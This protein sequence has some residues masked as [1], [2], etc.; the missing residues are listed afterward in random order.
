MSFA[1]EYFHAKRAETG[2]FVSARSVHQKS[3][4]WRTCWLA[5]EA[6]KNLTKISQVW[7]G[8]RTMPAP[9]RW[10]TSTSEAPRDSQRNLLW[11]GKGSADDVGD[12]AQRQNA[13]QRLG[14]AYAFCCLRTC[15]TGGVQT[16]KSSAGSSHGSIANP[17][18]SHA[19][20]WPCCEGYRTRG[21]PDSQGK[22]WKLVQNSRCLRIRGSQRPKR[23]NIFGYVLELHFSDLGALQPL[24]WR[25]GSTSSSH[26]TKLQMFIIASFLWEQGCVFAFWYPQKSKPVLKRFWCRTSIYAALPDTLEGHG[27]EHFRSNWCLLRH[28]RQS[29][30]GLRGLECALIG[31]G[32]HAIQ[33]ASNMLSHL[34]V[35]PAKRLSGSNVE[36]P[37]LRLRTPAVPA[38]AVPWYSRHCFLLISKIQSTGLCSWYLG[39]LLLFWRSKNANQALSHLV[40]ERAEPVQRLRPRQNARGLG[41]R[42]TLK[43]LNCAQVWS[44]LSRGQEET[45][46]VQ[47]FKPVGIAVGA[48]FSISTPILKASKQLTGTGLSQNFLPTEK[49]NTLSWNRRHKRHPCLSCI[50]IWDSNSMVIMLAS[51]HLGTAEQSSTCFAKACWNSGHFVVQNLCCLWIWSLACVICMLTYLLFP[52]PKKANLH[53]T[54]CFSVLFPGQVEAKVD[55]PAELDRK[56][57]QEAVQLCAVLEPLRL[58]TKLVE[59]EER[60]PASL[61]L[62]LFFQTSET[63][64]KRKGS[65]PLQRSFEK[66]MGCSADFQLAPSP[67]QLRD[68]LSKDIQAIRAKHLTGTTGDDLLAASTFLTFDSNNMTCGRVTYQKTLCRS[69]LLTWH[70]KLRASTRTW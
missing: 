10:S 18:R 55:G 56:E 33:L 9:A 30:L 21:G 47:F 38:A 29:E 37:H 64:K 68:F 12:H 66:G 53:R 16:C 13:L 60:A 1:H 17:Q 25:C 50:Q 34:Y 69:R 52:R 61:Y 24:R 19:W 2:I 65:L 58:A 32:A 43:Q 22:V 49:I 70:L 23:G 36:H 63:L 8:C 28:G 40:T 59:G 44:V 11:N 54:D 14:R 39:P 46:C 45:I 15:Q 27:V 31:C 42:S 48:M 67:W 35:L 4:L 57:I 26:R 41:E 6:G 51:A 20:S 62:P 7:G 5:K 3:L